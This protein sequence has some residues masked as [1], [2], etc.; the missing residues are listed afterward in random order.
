MLK[1][2]ALVLLFVLFL[3]SIGFVLR[4][5]F[6][7]GLAGRTSRE[8]R[9]GRSHKRRPKNGNVDID[10]IPDKDSKKD[11]GFKG[12]DYVEYEDVT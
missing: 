5:L 3:R 8:F 9:E 2:L 6:G 7:G 10:Y 11:K 4:L 1:L 12:G